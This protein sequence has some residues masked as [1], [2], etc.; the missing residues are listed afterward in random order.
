MDIKVLDPTGIYWRRTSSSWNWRFLSKIWHN[1][2]QNVWIRSHWCLLSFGIYCEILNS[3]KLSRCSCWTPPVSTELRIIS[4]II[5]WI[6]F[7]VVSCS[8]KCS[9]S[10]P[11]ECTEN[12]SFVWR[13]NKCFKMFGLDPTGVYWKNCFSVKCY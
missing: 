3:W 5:S 10:I 6:L 7:G 9:G 13:Y 1:I 11:R 12:F 8:A 2:S 4:Q